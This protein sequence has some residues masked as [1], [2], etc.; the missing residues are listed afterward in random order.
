MFLLL[1]WIMH[2]NGWDMLWYIPGYNRLQPPRAWR[3]GTWFVGVCTG[4]H[5]DLICIKHSCEHPPGE[6]SRQCIEKADRLLSPG[7]RTLWGAC[8]RSYLKLR[9]ERQR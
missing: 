2:R 3:P 1:D 8:L 9:R 7:A 6:H 5:N 4:R